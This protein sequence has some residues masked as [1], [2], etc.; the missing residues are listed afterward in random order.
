MLQSLSRILGLQGSL[1]Q[2]TDKPAHNL[3]TAQ[4]PS[5]GT[6]QF[7]FSRG[8]AHAHG[9]ACSGDC[10]S[11]AMPGHVTVVV[12]SLPMMAHMFLAS[13]PNLLYRAGAAL[14]AAA[15]GRLQLRPLHGHHPDDAGGLLRL[16]P[17]VT[18]FAAHLVVFS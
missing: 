14:A 1:L 18:C 6:E 4:P 12:T 10:T 13:V 11:H 3:Q 8:T 5:V 15:G 2:R 16:H 9:V 7:L 17:G